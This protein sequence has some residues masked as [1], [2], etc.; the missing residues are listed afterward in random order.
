MPTVKVE[1]LTENEIIELENQADVVIDYSPPEAT[2]VVVGGKQIYP[3]NETDILGEVLRTIID[4][5]TVEKFEEL[6]WNTT[7]KIVVE[8]EDEIKYNF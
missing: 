8:D 5:I 3:D 6:L 4:E 2:F 7:M 1:K